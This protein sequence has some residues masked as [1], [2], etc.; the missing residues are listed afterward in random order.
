MMAADEGLNIVVEN[1]FTIWLSTE[2]ST[3]PTILHFYLLFI[4]IKR[5]IKARAV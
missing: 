5:R 3:E 2:Y 1:R 4:R